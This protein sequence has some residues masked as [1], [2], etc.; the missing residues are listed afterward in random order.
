MAVPGIINPHDVAEEMQ[1]WG[2]Q[3]SPGTAR[4][5]TPSPSVCSFEERERSRAR[6]AGARPTVS[7]CVVLATAGAVATASACA[8]LGRLRI[9]VLS[10]TKRS[11][12]WR[13]RRSPLTFLATSCRRFFSFVS[14]ALRARDR[15]F[16]SPQRARA[17]LPQCLARCERTLATNLT[18]ATFQ[19]ASCRSPPQAYEARE[20]GYCPRDSDKIQKNSGNPVRL[21]NFSF[22]I[23]LFSIA[24]ILV[25]S[26]K[27]RSVKSKPLPKPKVPPIRLWSSLMEDK[28]S[29]S[30]S[31][32][33]GPDVSVQN[34]L[35]PIWS[36]FFSS[37]PVFRWSLALSSTPLCVLP[38][39]RFKVT[40]RQWFSQISPPSGWPLQLKNLFLSPPPP[41]AESED[42]RRLL[43]HFLN[44]RF[45]GKRN[46]KNG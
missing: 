34:Y 14:F 24:I 1:D 21:G 4:E 41:A 42:Q 16:C 29:K 37:R 18:A 33:M 13:E 11:A 3:A 19:E 22:V 8:K 12:R 10:A 43:V 20:G 7:A 27:Q 32:S 45:F 38:V 2:Q 25:V 28:S 23:R 35:G 15:R 36:F 26:E 40:C 39:A 5:D 6:L 17:L 46:W 30:R 44:L 31:L 9:T